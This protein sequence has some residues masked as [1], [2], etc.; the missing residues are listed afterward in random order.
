[1]RRRDPRLQGAVLEPRDRSSIAFAI[2]R[3]PSGNLSP[4]GLP[5]IAQGGMER[6]SSR[7]VA[8]Y[9]LPLG[10]D[11]ADGRLKTCPLQQGQLRDSSLIIVDD[12]PGDLGR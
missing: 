7:G 3:D 8:A 2:N 9:G 4:L 12:D 11:I 1:M 10:T 5:G 6:L